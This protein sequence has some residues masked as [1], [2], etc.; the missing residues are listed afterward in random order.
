MQAPRVARQRVPGAIGARLIQRDADP[1][2]AAPCGK[3]RRDHPR[4]V[5]H[6][7]IARPQQR[8]QFTHHAIRKTIARDVQQ[9]RRVARA[10]G[11]LGDAV[12]R[13]VEVEIGQSHHAGV[14]ATR[15]NRRISGIAIST[16]QS[17]PTT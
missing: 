10:G 17:F 12:R 6:Q 11:M 15:R 13:Q 1:C 9:P 4:V 5:D 2:V 8:R 7:H 3:L 14:G 16:A